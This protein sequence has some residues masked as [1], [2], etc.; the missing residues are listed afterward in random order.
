[1]LIEV[2]NIRAVK[3]CLAIFKLQGYEDK[4]GSVI[5]VLSLVKLEYICKVHMTV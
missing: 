4:N 3:Y 1:M 5:V 2:V